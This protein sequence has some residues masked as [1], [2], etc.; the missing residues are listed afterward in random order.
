MSDSERGQLIHSYRRR[1]SCAMVS[2][3]SQCLL[4]RIGYRGEGAR[5]VAERRTQMM[6]RDEEARREMRFHHESHMRGRGDR[7]LGGLHPN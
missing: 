5:K 2:S 1:L 6:R 7:R 3:Q 4:S